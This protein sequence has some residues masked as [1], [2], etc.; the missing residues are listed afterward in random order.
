MRPRKSRRLRIA[1]LQ[2]RAAPETRAV[3][4]DV[5]ANPLHPPPYAI[6]M[7]TGAV[8]VVGFEPQREAYE[9][10]VAEA[11]ENEIYVNAALGRTGAATL[12]IYPSGGLTSLFP[13]KRAALRWLG[14]FE[15][16]PDL[17]TEA[18]MEL[19]ALDDCAEVP[20]VDLL[21]IDIQGG[22]RDV[23]ASGR[24]KLAGAVCVIPE[25]RYYQ[26]YEGE[27][28]L[29]E[30]DAELRDQGFVLHKFLPAI[31]TMVPNSQAHRLDPGANRNQLIDGDAVYIRPLETP[32][33]LSDDQLKKMAL[34]AAAVFNSHDL[35]L[36]CLDLLVARGVVDADVPAAYVDLLPEDMI[37][38][39]RRR[40][41]AAE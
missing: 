31:R 13:L 1:L 38:Q 30:L 20:P 10:L 41:A 36:H 6:A 11:R 39:P 28:T 33:T 29:A 40:R 2:E 16:Q 34:F 7:E 23:I 37:R 5:G 22:E 9:A 4:C 27:P 17:V 15:A 21:K 19:T 18:T 8:D 24:G 26:L 35:C 12:R 3:I 14:K 32:E 25:V